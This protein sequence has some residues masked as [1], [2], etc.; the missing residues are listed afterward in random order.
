MKTNKSIKVFE[1]HT[2]KIGEFGFTEDHLN[3]LLKL[4]DAHAGCYFTPT[5]KGVKFN[6]YVGVLQVKGLTIE[7]H[8]KADK[9]D[10]DEKW[11]DVLIPMLKASGKLNVKDAGNARLKK[12]HLN[13][14]EIY[15]EKYLNELSVLL[16]KGFIKQYRKNT[17]NVTALKGKLEFAANLRKNLVHK[18]R[19]YTTHQ[20]YDADHLLHQVLFKA[21]RIVDKLC[22]GSYLS[23]YVKRVEFQFPSVS[24]KLITSKEVST[25]KLNRKSAPYKEALELAKLIILNYSPDLKGGNQE[26]LALLFDMN[27]LWES[28]VLKSLQKYGQK[29]NNIFV[30]GQESKNFISN[31]TLSPDIRICIDEED[32]IIDTKW[33]VPKDAKASVQDLRQMYTYGRYWNASKAILLYPGHIDKSQSYKQFNNDNDPLDHTC[34]LGFV[35]VLSE[36]LEHNLNKNL[37]LQIVDLLQDY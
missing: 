7:I 11:K 16:H 35:S 8:P 37:G 23:D 26:M 36:N 12:Q 34:K 30:Y 20:V 18:E 3:L 9:Y 14:L 29:Y 32:F 15:F 6:Q 28:Y 19:F 10:A 2:L 22:Q 27:N 31:H 17:A 21:L 25:I 13:L 1:H 24:S 4:N 5:Y 33:K